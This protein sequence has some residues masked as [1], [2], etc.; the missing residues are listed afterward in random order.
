MLKLISG[1]LVGG[2]NYNKIYLDPDDEDAFNSCST[3]DIDTRNK[4]KNTRNVPT[5]PEIARKVA[6][7]QKIQLDK[8][9]YI[10]YEMI[11]CTFLLGLVN[12]GRDPL[13]NLGAYLQKS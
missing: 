9:Q 13:T 10:P 12:D 5:L 3:N 8:K 1:T 11:A 4:A 2:A 6:K 7:L